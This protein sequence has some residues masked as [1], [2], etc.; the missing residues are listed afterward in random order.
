[1]L[2][3]IFLGYACRSKA[4]GLEHDDLFFLVGPSTR[5][6][7]MKEVVSTICQIKFGL[8]Q[9]EAGC[10]QCTRCDTLF[11]YPTLQVLD[12]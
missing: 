11:W 2:N 1:M 5:M 12:I 9:S 10:P 4:E 3:I 7:V 8:L 6:H